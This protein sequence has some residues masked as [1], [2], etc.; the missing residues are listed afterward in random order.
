PPANRDGILIIDDD[1]HNQSYSPDATVEQFYQDILS[2]YSGSK[3]FIKRTA[4]SD[5]GNTLSDARFRH[6][7]Y[8][9]LQKY[10][11][12]I[13]HSDNISA[14]G[15]L[16]Y[17]I[18]GLALYLLRGG[19]LVISH[20]Y[21]LASLLEDVSEFG[22]RYTFLNYLGI[23]SAP[24]V[25]R[26][27]ENLNTNYYFQKA[28][29]AVT[30]YSDVNLQFGT[31]ENASFFTL[32]NIRHGLSAVAYFPTTFG[33]TIYSLGCKPTDYSVSPP[34]QAQFNLLNNQSV[35]IRRVNSNNSKTYTFGFPLSYMKVAETKAMMNKIISEVM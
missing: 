27:S 6:Y 22:S 18:D 30:G 28:I 10:K 5:P 29:A 33:E 24:G 11:L 15:N 21:Q 17:D 34:S 19:N 12:V 23:N 35:G 32:A 7:A 16:Q 9:D 3:T 13:Y 14:K 26:V 8:S 2:D 20:S 4:L 1:K 31:G 25:G